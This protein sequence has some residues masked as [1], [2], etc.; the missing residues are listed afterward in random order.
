MIAKSHEIGLSLSRISFCFTINATHIHTHITQHPTGTHTPLT[1][2][3]FSDSSRSNAYDPNKQYATTK[4]ISITCEKMHAN[5]FHDMHRQLVQRPRCRGIFSSWPRCATFGGILFRIPLVG[6]FFSLVFNYLVIWSFSIRQQ[7]LL[8]RVFF[9][10][11]GLPNAPMHMEWMQIT[12]LLLLR[13]LFRL[14]TQY[15]LHSHACEIVFLSLYS[16]TSHCFS[17]CGV[18][19][20]G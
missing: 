3:S 18:Y 7:V 9:L 16:T 19:N 14:F 8:F 15:S 6:F 5:T 1:F 2:F 11:L 4:L 10:F 12:I 20:D 13:L 17:L